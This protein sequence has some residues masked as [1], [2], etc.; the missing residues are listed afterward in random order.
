MEREKKDKEW[1][2]ENDIEINIEWV[3][4]GVKIPKK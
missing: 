3:R 1:G 4:V 2:K